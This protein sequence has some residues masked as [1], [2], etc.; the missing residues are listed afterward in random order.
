MQEYEKQ[1][2]KVKAPLCTAKAQEKSRP[3]HNM[4]D[5][6]YSKTFIFTSHYPGKSNNKEVKITVLEHK[7]YFFFSS[8][9]YWCSCSSKVWTGR[10]HGGWQ[11]AGAGVLQWSHA[12]L[13]RP[14]HPVIL[15]LLIL[16]LRWESLATIHGPLDS[17]T[18]QSWGLE[19]F[20]GS[21]LFHVSNCVHYGKNYTIILNLDCLDNKPAF[22][23]LNVYENQ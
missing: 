2:R 6:S 9:G 1:L 13:P 20:K 4:L 17:V 10:L 7:H 23:G 18:I 16:L 21:E 15:P 3:S 22:R 19:K 8:G 5:S 14:L 12:F 11:R